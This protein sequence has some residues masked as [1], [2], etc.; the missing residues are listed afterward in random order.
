MT[1]TQKPRKKMRPAK[2]I[3]LTFLAA[4]AVGALLLSLPCAVAEGEEV[5]GL[6]SL[7]TSTTSVCVTGLV[8]V[9]TF[10]HWSLFGQIVILF[11]IQLGGMGIV[12]VT[13]AL[14][15]LLHK[16]LTMSQTL[17]LQESYNL[18]SPAGLRKFFVRVITGTLATELIGACLYAIR[19]VPRFGPVG[20]WY[21][22]FLSISAFCN[23][24]M[25][26]LG[27]D[28][29]IPFRD[30]PLVMTVTMILIV[31]GG[32]GYVVWFDVAGGVR[33]GIKKR[34]TPLT[35]FK[36]FNEH[37]RLVLSLTFFLILSG[38][39]LVF[40]FEVNNPDTLGGM[41]LDQKI[42]NCLF[43]SITFRTAG[44]AT[45]PQQ[46]LT[47][48]ASMLGCLFMFIGGSPVGCAGGVKTVTVCIVFMNA[49][50]FI[51]NRK[52]TVIFDKKVSEDMI[53]KAG[54]IV[55]VSFIITFMMT[56][57]LMET[58]HIG[59]VDAAYEM[60]SATGTVGLSRGL[61]STLHTGG[62]VAVIIAMFLGRIGPI[63]MALFFNARPSDKNNLHYAEGRFLAG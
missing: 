2:I 35:V 53:R 29:L 30:D 12:A 26:I 16:K 59:F 60:F 52:E 63:S 4:I 11:L 20:A 36:R 8:V 49:V 41:T 33:N 17:M 27:P 15:L 32:L 25:D 23:A 7:F 56:L 21:A 47:E 5:N 44:F 39:L 43:Q 38:A 22:L 24:G 42:V 51:R 57:I 9:D 10:S 40:A 34:Y 31:L 19:F 54:A 14:M 61:T 3:P 6:T 58:D 37:T 28:S 48:P 1:P 50:S 62:R 13:S 46:M 18:S 45:I 55:L